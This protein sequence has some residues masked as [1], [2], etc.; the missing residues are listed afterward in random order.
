MKQVVYETPKAV[1]LSEITNKSIIGIQWKDGARVMLIETGTATFAGVGLS[2]T[3]YGKKTVSSKKA[4]VE[5]AIRQESVKAFEFTT[6]YELFEWMI[7]RD[8]S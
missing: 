8:R 6:P 2:L 1:G 4:F 7:D 5:D 3:I